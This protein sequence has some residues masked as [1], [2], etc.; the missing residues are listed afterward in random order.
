MLKN[1]ELQVL[2][3]MFPTLKE[4]GI[5]FT[6]KLT[7]IANAFKEERGNGM[8]IQSHN[9]TKCG[10]AMRIDTDN[11]LYLCP[12]CGMSFDFD[13]F[14]SENLMRSAYMALGHADYATAKETFLRLL[15]DDPH[16]F[17]YLRGLLFASSKI[18]GLSAMDITRNSIPSEDEKL[19]SCIKE[20]EESGKEY[21]A[22]IKNAGV[23]SEKYLEND[24]KL[25]A[26]RKQYTNEEEEI[27]QTGMQIGKYKK[28]MLESIRAYASL[29]GGWRSEH[30]GIAILGTFLLL[31]ISAIAIGYLALGFFVLLPVIGVAIVF[32]AIYFPIKID[33]IRKLKK[34]LASHEENRDALRSSIEELKK[35]NATYQEEYFSELQAASESD[36]EPEPTFLSPGGMN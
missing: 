9:C 31:V 24:E 30:A 28:W 19:K 4:H 11:Q 14:E 34:I 13:Y 18:G 36:P 2:K 32:S 29:S 21:F 7:K 8:I 15:K 23:L 22:H 27:V 33:K 3:C 26:L 1:T 25:E 16:N 17:S 6:I 5:S 35:A 10:G 20:T 12:F